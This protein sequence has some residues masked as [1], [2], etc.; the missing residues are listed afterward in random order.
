MAA[1]GG[2]VFVVTRPSNTL[3]VWNIKEKRVVDQQP[4]DFGEMVEI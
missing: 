3:S 2:K 4:I 1:A